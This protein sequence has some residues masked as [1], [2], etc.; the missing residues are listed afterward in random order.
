MPR[1]SSRRSR[2]R[3]VKGS[4]NFFNH[5]S[6][7]DFNTRIVDFNLKDLPDSMLV[8]ALINVCEAVR[9]RM[10]FNAK[11]NVRTWLYVEEMQSMFAYPT[12][13]NYFS[14][15]S[16]EGRKFGLLLTGTTSTARRCSPTKR[17]EISSLTR[18]SSCFSSSPRSTV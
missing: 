3:F 5:Q 7:V 4:M 10:Y 11:R 6:N 9:N 12:V 2:Q 14:R 13:L 16:N 15:F 17:R 1:T 18:T 8:F